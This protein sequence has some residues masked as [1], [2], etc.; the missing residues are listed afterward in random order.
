MPPKPEYPKRLTQVLK[1]VTAALKQLDS[2]NDHADTLRDVAINVGIAKAPF[3]D[4]V[5]PLE[6]SLRPLFDPEVEKDRLL[7]SLDNLPTYNAI[8]T[9]L[10]TGII[11]AT[12]TD[13]HKWPFYHSEYQID[14]MLEA[15]FEAWRPLPKVVSPVAM[16]LDIPPTPPTY[17]RDTV[18]PLPPSSTPCPTEFNAEMLKA[19]SGSSSE[20]SRLPTPTPHPCRKGQV[21]AQ[22]YPRSCAPGPHPPPQPSPLNLSPR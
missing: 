11:L 3:T 16:L 2:L 6:S 20:D 22:V 5:I 8:K 14:K 19:D 12:C 21:E 13:I 15:F 9:L 18:S 17:D 4:L 1:T 10:Y 7:L